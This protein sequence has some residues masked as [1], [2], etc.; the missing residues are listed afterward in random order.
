[1]VD[2]VTL[3]ATLDD[4]LLSYSA[5][6]V[7]FLCALAST[8]IFATPDPN[9][10]LLDSITSTLSRMPQ[11]PLSSSVS[12]LIADTVDKLD[13]SRRLS[14]SEL[15]IDYLS[16]FADFPPFA[17]VSSILDRD[18]SEAG[19]EFDVLG[20]ETALTA[21]DD[22]LA[23]HSPAHAPLLSLASPVPSSSSTLDFDFTITP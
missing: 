10:A 15:D 16:A 6:L 21:H 13:S 14:T 12:S 17:N 3:L 20:V 4:T 18:D 5:G 1:M 8:V 11:D 9:I 19:G 7:S 2:A 23:V 22:D